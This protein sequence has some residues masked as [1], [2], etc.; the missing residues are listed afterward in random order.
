MTWH[1]VT[2][3]GY[4]WIHGQVFSNRKSQLII[5]N[6]WWSA[7]YWDQRLL[8]HGSTWLWAKFSQSVCKGTAHLLTLNI[9]F[10]LHSHSVFSSGDSFLDA[11]HAL[12][13]HSMTAPVAATFDESLLISN[14]WLVSSLSVKMKT[15]QPIKM[16]GTTH[17]MTQHHIPDKDLN[18]Q[19]TLWCTHWNLQR[20]DDVQW[21]PLPTATVHPD[22]FVDAIFVLP[23]NSAVCHTAPG[24]APSLLLFDWAHPSLPPVVQSEP[25]TKSS[26]MK[27]Y[28]LV[29]FL[30]HLMTTRCH[31]FKTHW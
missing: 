28:S 12:A 8:F 27:L 4:R 13:F 23:T 11:I 24:C 6:G 30:T 7:P 16:S 5:H 10:Y 22:P 3:V 2:G 17:P 29:T 19:Q 20:E 1:C 9:D 18:L 25:T 31:I 14:C 15:T 21:L 26:Y